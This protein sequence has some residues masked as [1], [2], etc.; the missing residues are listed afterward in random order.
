MEQIQRVRVTIDLNVDFE[1]C[2]RGDGHKKVR[3]ALIRWLV[4]QLDDEL[5]VDFDYT[6][7]KFDEETGRY[8]VFG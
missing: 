7:L 6:L 8:E 5:D 3:K 4:E 1:K 2:E